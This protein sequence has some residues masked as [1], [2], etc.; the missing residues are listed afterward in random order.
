MIPRLAGRLATV[1]TRFAH[2]H[3]VHHYLSTGCLHGEH[4]YC[5]GNTGKVGAKKPAECKFC[6][7]RCTCPCHD[8]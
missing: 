3:G 4:G 1:L 2:R 5:Q 7:A 8:S 6:G